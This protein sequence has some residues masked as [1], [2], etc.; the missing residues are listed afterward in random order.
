LKARWY[1]GVKNRDFIKMVGG[2]PAA[3]VLKVE[4]PPGSAWTAALMRFL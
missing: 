4:L 2:V 1:E 3:P